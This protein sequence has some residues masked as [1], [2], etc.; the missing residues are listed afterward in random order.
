VVL[1]ATKK[2]RTTRQESF[3]GRSLPKVEK[4]EDVEKKLFLISRINGI[5]EHSKRGDEKDHDARKC[6]GKSN[7]EV[8]GGTNDLVRPKVNAAFTHHSRKNV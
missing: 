1:G 2:L 3:G 4:R 7:E 8:G 5:S 6:L